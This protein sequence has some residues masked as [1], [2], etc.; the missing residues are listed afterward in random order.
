MTNRITMAFR[1]M[2]VVVLSSVLVAILTIW[3]MNTLYI[4]RA[5]SEAEIHA[6][7]ATRVVASI[8]SADKIDNYL[9]TLE[10]DKE[11]DVILSRIIEERKC[12]GAVHLYV[13]RY[14][15]DGEIFIVGSGD[16]PGKPFSL[17][18]KETW[19]EKEIQGSETPYSLI[20]SRSTGMINSTHGDLV[21]TRY[22]ITRVDGSVAGYVS[23][24]VYLADVLVSTYNTRLMITSSMLI[25]LIVS[26]FINYVMIKAVVIRPI[27]NVTNHVVEY[28]K[29]LSQEG[30]SICDKN[31][32]Q[33]FKGKYMPKNEIKALQY[34]IDDMESLINFTVRELKDAEEHSKFMFETAPFSCIIWDR[35]LK[36]VDSNRTAL[37]MFGFASTEELIE[38]FDGTYD[39]YQNDDRKSVSKLRTGLRSAFRNGYHSF[40]MR[41]K[42]TEDEY[43]PTK[44]RMV[45]IKYKEEYRVAQYIVDLSGVEAMEEKINQ[46]EVAA[47]Q[48]YYDQTTGIHNR[49]YLDEG[50]KKLMSTLSRAKCYLS[51]MMIDI[52]KF[53]QYNDNYGHGKGDECLKEIAKILRNSLERVDDFVVRYGGEEFA[54]LLP[55]TNAD[56]AKNIADKILQEIEKANI[57]H[58]TSWV[59]PRVTVSMGVV[60]GVVQCKQD[61]YEFI[62]AADTLL[63]YSKE[64]GRNKYTFA[65]MG[66]IPDPD[67]I[68]RVTLTGAVE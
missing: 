41:Y 68:V 59:I 54:I 50:L 4:K 33:K 23:A 12:F 46:L 39:E 17:G 44:V 26:A 55:N 65:M 40:E 43:I 53:K 58:E 42:I 24:D 64:S 57:P 32:L 13:S 38:K 49:R 45:S 51:V 61:G 21:I 52:D 14:T 66:E 25:I 6:R 29:S 22:P 19:K 9:E 8:I 62:D 3:S 30:S 27:V 15:D 37:Q 34:T 31:I 60:T 36:I 18:E 63:Y 5:T 11:Y 10:M 7:A 20:N 56:G 16:T 35:K 1:L 2:V 67:S 47:R 48:A 28:T